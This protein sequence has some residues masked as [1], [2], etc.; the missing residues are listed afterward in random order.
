MSL[1]PSR[2]YSATRNGFPAALDPRFPY[3]AGA[4]PFLMPPLG[5]GV[6]VPGVP[7]V[8][9]VPGVV[10][11]LHHLAGPISAPLPASS[12]D[13]TASSRGSRAEREEEHHHHKAA[14]QAKSPPVPSAATSSD[15][16]LFSPLFSGAVPSLDMSSTQALVSMVQRSH[17]NQ[18]ETYLKGAIKRPAE[19]SPLSPLDLSSAS[20]PVKKSKKTSDVYGVDTLLGLPS[21]LLRSSKERLAT[22]TPP[23]RALSSPRLA[24]PT[25]APGAAPGTAP[26][27]PGKAS[28]LTCSSLCSTTPGQAS[29]EG[30][31]ATD[32]VSIQHWS[33]GDVCQFVGSIDL[34][35]EYVQVSPR[36]YI[37]CNGRDGFV[38][39][40][41]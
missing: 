7:G 13:S 1:L 25:S 41:L 36:L 8:P 24:V 40:P 15:S 34:C 18:L 5:A 12:K 23:S 31:C 27:S 39:Y 11:P 10:S 38:A 22:R 33:V 21:S 4:A 32:A 19:S 28:P 16:L 17:Q 3:K 20:A 2:F 26:G 6:G 30:P 37:R 14:T 29:A 9:V 35:V